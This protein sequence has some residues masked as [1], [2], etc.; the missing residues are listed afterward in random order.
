MQ[1]AKLQIRI[2]PLLVLVTACGY[3]RS[4]TWEDDRKNYRRAFGASPP[5]SVEVVRSWY[6]R[7]PH[8]T[9]E[10]AYYFAFVGN[11]GLAEAFA[12]ANG[13]TEIGSEGLGA[14]EFCFERPQWF[15][16]GDFDSYSVWADPE[17]RRLILRR[18]G[19]DRVF[20]YACQL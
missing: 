8:F 17:R 14:S 5:D 16:P 11:A 13:M 3:F 20:L 15:A 7:S 12:A 1:T 9:R 2:V 19:T 18:E 10:E 4:G 6:W